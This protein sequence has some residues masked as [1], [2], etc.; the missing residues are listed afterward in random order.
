MLTHAF[1]QANASESVK[2]QLPREVRAQEYQ[3]ALK[4]RC[5]RARL[6]HP[7]GPYK[8]A[9]HGLTRCA[10]LRTSYLRISA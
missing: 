9:Q 3:E 5:V 8:S 10:V 6:Q 2:P 4:D 1:V 7:P